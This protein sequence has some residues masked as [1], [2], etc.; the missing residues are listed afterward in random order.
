LVFN[1]AALSIQYVA[2]ARC[3]LPRATH[4]SSPSGSS[5]G[6][7]SFNTPTGEINLGFGN[8]Q[9]GN[10][11][12]FS[13]MRTDRYLDP[14]ELEALHDNGDSA[15]LFDRFDSGPF[16]LNLQVARSSFDVPN[17]IDQDSGGQ[18]QHQT[19]NSFNVAPGYSQVFGTKTLFTANG[20]V[21]R[22]HLTYSPSPDPFADQPATVSQDR[23]LTN[24]GLKADVSVT[25]GAHNIKLGGTI[26][27]TRLHEGFT[28]G[29]TDPSFNAPCLDANGDPLE[30]PALTSTAQCRGARV[31]QLALPGLTDQ[32]L[33]E[34]A[35]RLGGD[36]LESHVDKL[37]CNSRHVA[38]VVIGHADE[39]CTA[40]RKLLSGV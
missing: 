28:L 23:T 34:A 40:G 20:F 15:S 13:G 5:A 30:N 27:A 38:L 24:F 1:H 22:D 7:G 11:L 9:M 33:T 16:H 18:D 29:L 37:S 6:V 39:D 31:S 25:E 26:A 35:M 4:A 3:P 21:R 36:Q 2:V 14:P 32:A 10:F 17:T 12:S 8:H 19:I